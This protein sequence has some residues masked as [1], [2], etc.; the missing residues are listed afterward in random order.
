M[1]KIEPRLVRA[2]DFIAESL[3]KR[4]NQMP[5]GSDADNVRRLAELFRNSGRTGM[6]RVWEEEA[7]EK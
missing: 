2:D 3:E 1:V 7:L 5:Q 4:A 6:L